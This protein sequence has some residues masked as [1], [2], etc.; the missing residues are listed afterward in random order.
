MQASL[1]CFPPAGPAGEDPREDGELGTLARCSEQCCVSSCAEPQHQVP[2][3]RY[4]AEGSP[5]VAWGDSMTLTFTLVTSSQNF[6]ITLM[7]I[8]S[9]ISLAPS[10]IQKQLHEARTVSGLPHDRVSGSQSPLGPAD[11][12]P[13][14]AL[15][16][17]A[18]SGRR[19]NKRTSNYMGCGSCSPSP[20]PTVTSSP[21]LGVEHHREH[22]QQVGPA[23][24]QRHSMSIHMRFPVILEEARSSRSR[25]SEQKGPVQ[26]TQPDNGRP[27]TG[28]PASPALP[29]SEAV[30]S[31]V[32]ALPSSP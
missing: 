25:V 13:F 19:D 32:P 20:P 31:C 6:L 21:R 7:K 16:C 28:V 24:P 12:S 2:G 17:Q 27:G 30:L 8:T 23:S 3:I 1:L 4:G 11:P 29:L 9:P 14:A 10:T 15:S 22:S 5:G 18:G 26:G